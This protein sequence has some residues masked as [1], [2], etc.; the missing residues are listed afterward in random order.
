MAFLFMLHL[1]I[2]NDFFS[3]VVNRTRIFQRITFPP[4]GGDSFYIFYLSVFTIILYPVEVR[5][6]SIT[7]IMI[8]SNTI[9]RQVINNG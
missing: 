5:R 3:T 7:Y 2:T 8:V 4:I 1:S 9:E 6:S